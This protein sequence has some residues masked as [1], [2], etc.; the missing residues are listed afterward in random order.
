MVRALG[1]G[2]CTCSHSTLHHAKPGRFAV[3]QGLMVLHDKKVLHKDIKP[4]NILQGNGSDGSYLWKI[5]DFG[6][7]K[8]LKSHDDTVNRTD[9]NMTAQVRK[10][11]STSRKGGLSCSKTVPFF[12]LL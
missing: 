1:P 9:A 6:E 10:D 4:G 7:A 11:S 2:F 12:R 8:V 3:A 5:C